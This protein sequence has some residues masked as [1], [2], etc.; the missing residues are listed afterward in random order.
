MSP[1]PKATI[2]RLQALPGLRSTWQG[3]LRMF[4][5]P[6]P[7]NPYLPPTQQAYVVWVDVADLSIRAM[8]LVA[9]DAGF[10]AVVQTLLKGME[11]PSNGQTPGRPHKVVVRD[12]KLQFFLRGALQGLDITAGCSQRLH[13]VDEVFDA[14]VAHRHRSV[15]KL[16]WDSVHAKRLTQ[17]LNKFW[18]YPLWEEFSEVEILELRF[19]LDEPQQFYVSVLGMA[20]IE[21]GLLMYRS[22][23]SL[24]RF[25]DAINNPA[26]R[27]NLPSM[28]A[29]FLQQ[30]CLFLNFEDFEGELPLPKMPVF[31]GFRESFIP[32]LGSIHPLEGVRYA[33][34]DQELAVVIVAIEALTRFK[35]NH[36]RVLAEA[37]SFPAL[38]SQMV[39]PNPIAQSQK[40][41]KNRQQP[42]TVTVKTLP[43][44]CNE[45]LGE[46]AG[47]A[48]PDFTPMDLLG[49]REDEPEFDQLQ[50]LLLGLMGSAGMP[51]LDGL[52]SDSANRNPMQALRKIMSDYGKV[53]PGI[54]S[55]GVSDRVNVVE[56]FKLEIESEWIPDGSLFYLQYSLTELG[57]PMM[58][59]S[60]SMPLVDHPFPEEKKG[61]S[62][63]K[64][65]R[66]LTGKG[67]AK[68][69]KSDP[70]TADMP[71]G[72]PL[73]C[74]QTSQ[75]KAQALIREWFA[76]DRPIA[77]GTVTGK[78]YDEEASYDLLILCTARGRLLILNDYWHDDPN[79]LSLL[80]RWRD[81]VAAAGGQCSMAL[82]KGVTGRNRGQFE[83]ADLIQIWD[84]HVLQ[85]D[86]LTRLAFQIQKGD[87]A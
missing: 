81:R 56:T 6:D 23:D 34:S 28:E 87:R 76:N 29:A 69:Q 36:E 5:Q 25:R 45:L 55:D 78:D 71:P 80:N 64:K 15:A 59:P 60:K 24:R 37:E 62:K 13:L 82:L 49:I 27:A 8:E 26:M 51:N 3:E 35:K 7:Q 31:K 48:Q 83:L 14:F 19:E 57:H 79:G 39:I 84:L 43:K 2:E 17:A 11:Y 16:I 54:A 77:V 58:P 32:D 61:L 52:N 67:M 30:D 42:I 33:L 50:Q 86:Q 10:E 53:N 72:I 40:I 75:P 41:P 73:L 1:L 9:D 12:R 68:K 85:T 18:D 47:T 63:G 65:S 44:V 38:T 21:R 22:L 66:K 46:S 74:L 20:G 4:S 70:L